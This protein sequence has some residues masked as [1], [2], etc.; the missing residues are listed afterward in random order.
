M[1]TTFAVTAEA[2]TAVL[3]HS[4]ERGELL[5]SEADI[6]GEVL[7]LSD[8]RVREIMTPRTEVVAIPA[9]AG[10]DAILET[11]RTTGHSRIP[12]FGKNILGLRRD[13]VVCRAKLGSGMF[14]IA[15]Q[16]GVTGKGGQFIAN[17]DQGV[18]TARGSE[19]S[20]SPVLGE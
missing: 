5:D 11:I 13:D 1:L 17:I 19:E 9:N 8:V 3:E 20:E 16:L 14:G 12:V 2:L 6:A 15:I 10:L 18:G 7:E 4:A